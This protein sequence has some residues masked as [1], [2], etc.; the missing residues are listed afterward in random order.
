MHLIVIFSLQFFMIFCF[1]FNSYDNGTKLVMYHNHCVVGFFT[2]GL[3][4]LTNL[5]HVQ[6]LLVLEIAII[7]LGDINMAS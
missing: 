6:I 2:N 5:L 4:H 3:K 7:N 1:L